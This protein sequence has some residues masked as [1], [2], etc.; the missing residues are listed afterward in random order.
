MRQS[1]QR[2]VIVQPGVILY[3]IGDADISGVDLTEKEHNSLS[4]VLG[5]IDIG[6][7]LPESIDDL[8]PQ[9]GLFEDLP[10]SGIL[11]G[12][13]F[14]HMPLGEE[15]MPAFMLLDKEEFYLSVDSTE[16]DA[17]AGLFL[18]H[19]TQGKSKIISRY[20]SYPYMEREYQGF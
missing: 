13:A 15:S 16:N 1:L 4:D 3:F 11:F 8:H 5:T 18:F 12:L 2:T 20:I 14:L 9:A 6:E 19:G 17:A 7:C 10:Q